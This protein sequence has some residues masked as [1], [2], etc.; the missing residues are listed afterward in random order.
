MKNENK[1]GKMSK[2][3]TG[4]LLIG[5]SIIAFSITIFFWI[6]SNYS[7]RQ[8]PLPSQI[9]H[10]VQDHG[11]KD[12][13]ESFDLLCPYNSERSHDLQFDT[14][15]HI[16]CIEEQVK[17]FQFYIRHE[18]FIRDKLGDEKVNEIA[19]RCVF[20]DILDWGMLKGKIKFEIKWSVE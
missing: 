10:N 14:M 4:E 19:S 12:I 1:R 15:M 2:Q 11:M 16:Q 20:G 6:L 5:L 8:L 3:R 7:K 13:T 9:I 18:K 17:G